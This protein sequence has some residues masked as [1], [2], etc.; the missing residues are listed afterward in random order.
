MGA[1]RAVLT[2]LTKTEEAR[3]QSQKVLLLLQERLLDQKV[4]IE[5]LDSLFENLFDLMPIDFTV[6]GKCKMI[7]RVLCACIL[8][9]TSNT[10]DIVVDENDI[11]NYFTRILVH[12][13]A[14]PKKRKAPN[15]F[16]VHRRR[17]MM[18][19]SV[20]RELFV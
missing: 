13:C 4:P 8:S 2:G 19:S 11:E 15:P 7:L 6:M 3:M 17:R 14:A 9:E 5:E 20:K 1:S 10:M 16:L 12:D 18:E